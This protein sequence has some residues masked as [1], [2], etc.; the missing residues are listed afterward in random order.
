M[1]GI[2]SVQNALVKRYIQ[3]SRELAKDGLFGFLVFLFYVWTE[4]PALQFVS[5][6]FCSRKKETE[7]NPTGEDQNAAQNKLQRKQLKKN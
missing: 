2:Q 1:G 5:T 4:I 6:A 7:I 3:E